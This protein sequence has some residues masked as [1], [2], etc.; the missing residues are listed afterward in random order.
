MFHLNVS[1]EISF[2]QQ[3]QFA[4]LSGDFNPIHVNP[5]IARRELFGE[6]VVHGMHL[7]LFSNAML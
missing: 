5:G 7:V 2:H 1:K 3:Q 4:A 6:I